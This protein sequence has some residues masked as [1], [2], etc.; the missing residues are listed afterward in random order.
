MPR[1]PLDGSEAKTTSSCPRAVAREKTPVLAPLAVFAFAVRA[2]PAGFALPERVARA[3][4]DL[5]FDAT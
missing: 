5:V 3:G 4:L 1:Y 2:P